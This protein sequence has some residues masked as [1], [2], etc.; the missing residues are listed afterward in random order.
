MGSEAISIDKYLDCDVR[1][2]FDFLYE[3]FSILKPIIN[4]YK[5]AIISDVAD[6]K[7]YNRKTEMGELGV[8]IQVS[9]ISNP[10]Q[11][12]AF[13][14]QSIAKAID[15]GYLD[16]EFFEHTDDP[17]ELIRRVTVYHSV[18]HD[19]EAFKSKLDELK[20]KDQ[21]VL[22]PYLLGQKTM[23]DLVEEM[24]IEYHSAVMRVYRIRKR[25]SNLVEPKLQ[26]GM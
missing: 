21:K 2:K 13:R 3:N 26:G 6:M 8:R 1:K 9:G 19:F 12:A 15:E 10:T 11:S 17:D 25:L 7:L 18:N 24:E 5:E 4:N 14:N 20:P 23:D 22:K 16:D